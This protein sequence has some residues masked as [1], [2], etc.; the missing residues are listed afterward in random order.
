MRSDKLCASKLQQQNKNRIDIPIPKGG[1]WKEGRWVPRRFKTQPGKFHEILRLENNSLW[2][3]ALCRPI[4][5]DGS[6]SRPTGVV[7]LP[8]ELCWAGFSPTALKGPTLGRSCLACWK[9]GDD[10][11]FWDQGGNPDDFCII[12]G[13]SLPP[14]SSRIAHV[15]SQ[16]ALWSCPIKT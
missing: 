5:A 3:N 10:F 16:S 12:F 9:Q 2:L 13:I 8:P 15:C 14:L 7:V 4:A 1:N 11:P 6:L